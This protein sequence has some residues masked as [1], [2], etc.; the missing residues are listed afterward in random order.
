ML[1]SAPPIS[2]GPSAGKRRERV[3]GATPRA[4]RTGAARSRGEAASGSGRVRAART[5]RRS[6]PPQNFRRGEV[7]KFVSDSGCGPK[8]APV[9]TTAGN[10]GCCCIFTRAFLLSDFWHRQ[11][12]EYSRKNIL[13]ESAFICNKCC[14]FVQ[15][16]KPVSDYRFQQAGAIHLMAIGRTFD[17]ADVSSPGK[18]RSCQSGIIS[19]F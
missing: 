2:A 3:S 15:Q 12:D 5:P 6:V 16:S 18:S 19:F 13:Q 7:A 1:I 8:A 10:A 14:R 17:Q 9:D 11:R 4:R